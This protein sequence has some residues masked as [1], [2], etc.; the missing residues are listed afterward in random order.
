VRGVIFLNEASIIRVLED[1]RFQHLKFV[2]VLKG[3]YQRSGCCGRQRYV[4]HEAFRK[5]LEDPSFA[6]EVLELKKAFNSTKVV[7]CAPGFRR[8][9]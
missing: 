5:A 3:A 2:K 6:Q 9:F 4:Q 7:V 1:V 8:E